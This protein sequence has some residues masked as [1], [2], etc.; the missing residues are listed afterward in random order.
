[1]LLTARRRSTAQSTRRTTWWTSCTRSASTLC[2]CT[3]Y[4]SFGVSG[5]NKGGYCSEHRKGGMLNV[6]SKWCAHRGCT[7][8]PHFGVA[9]SNERNFCAEHKKDRMVNA[10]ISKRCGHPGRTK[11]P[12]FGVSQSRTR[13]HCLQHAEEGMVNLDRLNRL[14]S[15]D[16]AG[17]YG[18]GRG[19]SAARVGRASASLA[20]EGTLT[21]HRSTAG[22]KMRS[23]CLLHPPTR[24]IPRAAAG[25][26]TSENVKLLP[27]C[28]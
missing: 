16:G 24:I 18:H 5:S 13:E 2:R 6:A 28:P 22:G 27:T 15:G 23:T 12:R 17:G 11:C 7:K 4:P 8:Y 10:I 1:M 14:P 9:G 26:Q 20:A 21:N 19:A 25:R 3:R